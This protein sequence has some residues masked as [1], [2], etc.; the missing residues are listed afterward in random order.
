M[1]LSIGAVPSA[2][3]PLGAFLSLGLAAMLVGPAP[4]QAQDPA[5]QAREGAVPPQEGTATEDRR[6]SEY[7]FA[8]S[9]A[10]RALMEAGA[11]GR[12]VALYVARKEGEL[13]HVYFGSFDFGG[14]AFGIAYEVVQEAPGSSDFE[15][16]ANHPEVAADP[17][18]TRA[19][20]AL[21]TA[22]D[23]FEPRSVR[24]YT[25]VWRDETG[26]WITYFVPEAAA[27][28]RLGRSGDQRVVVSPDARRVLESRFGPPEQ[29]PWLR[30]GAESAT[31]RDLVQILLSPQYAPLALITRRLVCEMNWEGE[32]QRCL[33]GAP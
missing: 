1:K 30:A 5:A 24:F 21:V 20:M 17:E 25:Y 32:I 13:W 23:A 19:A 8:V 3:A 28:G 33:V 6:I 12:R 22:M 18:L 11:E 10:M 9:Q 31:S 2:V 7:D 15:V 27:S 29:V 4:A 14:P 26:R 16:K